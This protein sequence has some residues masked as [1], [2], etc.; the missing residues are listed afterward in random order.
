[1]DVGYGN[2]AFIDY[3]KKHVPYVYGYDVTGVPL[4]GAY[5]MPEDL[6]AGEWRWLY[7]DDL[8]ALSKSVEL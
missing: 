4:N 6:A 7:P 1:M 3:A 5:V 8:K 2:G